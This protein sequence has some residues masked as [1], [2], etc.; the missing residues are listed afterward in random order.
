[1]LNSGFQPI[2]EKNDALG[3]FFFRGY[4]FFVRQERVLIRIYMM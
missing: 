2:Q 4:R 3:L 1:M